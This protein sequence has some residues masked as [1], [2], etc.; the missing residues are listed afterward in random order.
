MPGTLPAGID[1]SGALL[2]HCLNVEQPV[3]AQLTID[4]GLLLQALGGTN[5]D[6]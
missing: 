2:Y 6:A 5:D 1:D 3:A 4:E